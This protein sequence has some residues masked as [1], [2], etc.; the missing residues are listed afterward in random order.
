MENLFHSSSVKINSFITYCRKIQ[1]LIDTNN[2]LQ[3]PIVQ[4][5]EVKARVDI[6]DP[7][8]KIT[9]NIDISKN[10]LENLRNKTISALVPN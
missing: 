4:Y 2:F 5:P 7:K 10:T 1:N 6:K 9:S 3:L 8:N